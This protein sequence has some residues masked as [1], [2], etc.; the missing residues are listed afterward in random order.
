MKIEKYG[1]ELIAA[2]KAKNCKVELL[3][4]PIGL[5]DIMQQGKY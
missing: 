5:D 3:I 4:T 1:V 2:V